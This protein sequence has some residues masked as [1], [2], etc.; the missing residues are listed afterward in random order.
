MF[1]W[2]VF[3]PISLLLSN[4]GCTP[5]KTDAPQSTHTHNQFEISALEIKEDN[6]AGTIWTAQ[7]DE[8]SGDLEQTQVRN[9]VITHEVENGSNTIVLKAPRGTLSPMTHDAILREARVTDSF[10][11][12]IEIPNLEYTRQSSTIEGHGPILVQGPA[13]T[14]QASHMVYSFANGRLVLKGP[15]QGTV[16]QFKRPRSAR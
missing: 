14:L 6:D 2:F 15:I 12:T 8:A 9:L 1:R 3:L 4:Y 11:R 10:N 13:F 5:A 7:A 16:R